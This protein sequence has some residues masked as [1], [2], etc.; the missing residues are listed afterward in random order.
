MSSAPNELRRTI[1]IR[2]PRD[3]VW[4]ALTE[5]DLL[6]RWF[7]TIQARVDL[8][9]GGRMRFAWEGD[10]DEAVIEQVVP[11]ERLVFRWR[12]ERSERPF[13]TV[14]IELGD[15]GDGVT[16]LSL[17]ET[18]FSQLSDPEGSFRGNETGWAEELEELRGFLEVTPA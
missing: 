10:A 15:A 13:T 18:G 7:P 5:P 3:R 1:S 6:V 9:V 2:A 11:P 8:R 4:A 17:A 12:P 16:V 14:T